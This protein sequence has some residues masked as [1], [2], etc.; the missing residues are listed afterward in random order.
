MT[1]LQGCNL[2]NKQQQKTGGTS[3]ITIKDLEALISKF[4][5]DILKGL[6][7]SFPSVA[8]CLLFQ[9]IQSSCQMSDLVFYWPFPSKIARFHV[10]VMPSALPGHCEWYCYPSPV[11]DNP[12][13]MHFYTSQYLENRVNCIPH[14]VFY[15]Q[16]S[17]SAGNLFCSYIV[18]M[19]FR[20]LET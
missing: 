20:C 10:M 15:I 17:L 14:M 12:S 16:H 11:P 13:S 19:G 9:A 4:W 1:M 7:W 18:S 2:K 6:Y 5:I 3:N 8:C